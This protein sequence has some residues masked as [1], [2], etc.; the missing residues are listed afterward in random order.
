MNW[1]KKKKQN[2]VKSQQMECPKCGGTMTLTSGLTR[3][4][5][6]YIG[7]E[8]EVTDITGMLC[9]DCGELM[10]DWNEAQRIEKYVRGTVAEE[11]KSE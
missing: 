9:P 2:K 7:Q 1:F 11:N 8:V 5:H 3:T 6:N 10:F 4:F